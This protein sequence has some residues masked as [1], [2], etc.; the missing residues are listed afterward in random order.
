MSLM[1]PTPANASDT[2]GPCARARKN[3]KLGIMTNVYADL[4]LDEAARQ[5]KADG[6]TGVVSDLAFADVR[7]NPLEPDWTAAGKIVATLERTG[8]EIVGLFGYYNVVDPG[9]EATEARRGEDGNAPV[10]REA[11]GLLAGLHRDGNLQ[12]A[13]GVARRPGE[14]DRAGLS[15]VQGR[16]REARADGRESTGPCS[17]SS[18]LAE[19]HR[20]DRPGRAALPRGQLPVPSGW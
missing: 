11:A 13:V 5:I 9:H 8:I 10:A 17:R 1:G 14:P 20:L 2:T 3:L 18:L 19:H 7:F 15:P 16:A 6:F 12:P 4:P